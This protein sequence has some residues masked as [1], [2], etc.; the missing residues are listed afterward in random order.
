M[1]REK[2]LCTLADRL[3]KT[4]L[5]ERTLGALVDNYPLPEG[6]EP[7]DAWYASATAFLTSL[8][9]QYNSDV[10]QFKKDWESSHGTDG[11][12]IVG[13]SGADVNAAPDVNQELAR[14][15]EELRASQVELR[16][17]VAA[18]AEARRRSE[19]LVSVREYMRAHDCKN[20]YILGVVLKDAE[21]PDGKG[22]DE[23]GESLLG[24]YDAEMVKAYGKGVGPRVGDGTASGGNASAVDAYFA[25]KIKKYKSQGS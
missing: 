2:I 7:D 21:L 14:A 9:G 15:V 18:A 4:S 17:Q 12:V 19:L 11:G 23:I 13:A 16:E 3:G 25:A 6:G 5:S 20:E 8:Q 22:A 10:A 24:A 1:E